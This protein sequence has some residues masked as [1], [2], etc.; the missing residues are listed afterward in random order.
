VV[1]VDLKTPSHSQAEEVKADP[2]GVRVDQNNNSSCI[3]AITT[4]AQYMHLETMV[5]KFCLPIL[6]TVG[7]FKWVK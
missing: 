7:Y 3:G 5:Q 6:S 4:A 1:I 2:F